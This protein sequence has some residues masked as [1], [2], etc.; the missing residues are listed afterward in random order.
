MHKKTATEVSPVRPGKARRREKSK[1]HTVNSCVCSD[2][3]W[4]GFEMCVPGVCSISKSKHKSCEPFFFFFFPPHVPSYLCG[5][6]ASSRYSLPTV[7]F[8][9]THMYESDFGSFFWS[10]L[11]LGRF[12]FMLLF[13]EMASL[14]GFI[15]A[16][17]LL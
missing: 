17:V 8:L 6:E 12:C 7:P 9:G 1:T 3:S 14:F 11:H 15:A 13:S 2:H 4:L 5:C 16:V 10:F